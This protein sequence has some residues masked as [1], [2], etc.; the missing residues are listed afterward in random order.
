MKVFNSF[1]N[2]TRNTKTKIPFPIIDIY[3]FK[4]NKLSHTGIHNHADK[5]CI[6]WLLKGEIKENIYS[7][8]LDYIGTNIHVSPSISYIHNDKGFHSIKPI[9]SSIS[10]HFYYPKNH[11]TK[12]FI[13]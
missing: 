10:L 11:K 6:L 3:L 4:W 7:K 9:R 2:K 13:K 8:K 1:F 5:G 12:Y